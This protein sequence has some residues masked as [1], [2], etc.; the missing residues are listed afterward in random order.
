[1]NQTNKEETADDLDIKVSWLYYMEGKTQEEISVA[2]GLNRSKVLRILASARQNGVVQVNVTTEFSRCVELERALEQN[3]GL[4]RAIVVPSAT[5]AAKDFDGIGA[6]LG[7][8]ISEIL[9]DDMTIGLGWG[10]TLSRSLPHIDGGGHVGIKVISMLGGVTRV[11]G[12]NPSEFAWRLADRLS[13]ECLIMAAPVFAPDARTRNALLHH[14]GIND[15]VLASKALDLAIIGVGNLSPYSTVAQY[16]V[17][18]R[19]DMSNLQAAGAVGEI[20]CRFV[21]A[22]GTIIDHPLNDRVLAID[23]HDVA[24]ARKIVLAAGGWEKHEIVKASIKLLKPHVLVTDESVA[25]R[26][27]ATAKS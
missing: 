8:Y 19:D 1:M 26:L 21:D 12:E 11:S 10:R 6:A 16:F 14:S 13:A 9:E 7:Q 4:E 15:I 25:E 5:E 22:S 2:L 3:M 20:L 18:E 23:P 17:L 24:K 27:V